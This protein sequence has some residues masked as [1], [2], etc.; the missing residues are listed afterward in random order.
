M[1]IWSSIAH[2][3]ALT[4]PGPDTA[5]IIRQVTLH[6]RKSGFI[7]ALGIGFGISVH[8][9]LAISG[10]SLFILSNDLYKLLISIFGSSYLIYLSIMMLKTSKNIA[11]ST[12]EDYKPLN[13]FATGFITNIFN[14]KAFIFFV[15]LFTILIE[16]IDG[17]Y[18]YLYPIYFSITSC[19]WFVLV[20]YMLSLKNNSF[21]IHENKIIKY[22]M[23][24]LLC[25]IGLSIFFRSVYEYF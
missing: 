23:S 15:S 4:S 24:L 12:S 9:F 21:N 2:F 8:C 14:I 25:I 19:L 20:S 13:S 3:I 17:I 11:S 7:A 6:G 22:I 18:F 16:S 10:I 5:I 1:F